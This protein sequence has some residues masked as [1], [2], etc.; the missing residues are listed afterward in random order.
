V[1]KADR[2]AT[3][4]VAIPHDSAPDGVANT[5]MPLAY[6]FNTLIDLPTHLTPAGSVAARA[7]ELLREMQH[8][9]FFLSASF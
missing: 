2:R 7:A 3:E 4:S 9:Q 8:D 5:T 1:V 6:G